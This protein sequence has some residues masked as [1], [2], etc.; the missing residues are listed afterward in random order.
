[1]FDPSLFTFSLHSD[2][3][4]VCVC[5]GDWAQAGMADYALGKSNSVGQQEVLGKQLRGHGGDW[6]NHG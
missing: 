1:M 6:I 4:S 5:S 2:C 3:N